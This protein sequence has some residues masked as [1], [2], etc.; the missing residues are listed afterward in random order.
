MNT[1]RKNKPERLRKEMAK[2]YHH[3]D[4]RSALLKAAK[5]ILDNQG[6]EAMSLRAV[7]NRAGVSPSAPYHHFK[8]KNDLLTAI[9]ASGFD[10][11]EKSLEERAAKGSTSQEKL[12][13]SGIAYV[14]FALA[15]TAL[16]Q[17]MFSG[18]R[19]SASKKNEVASQNN[20]YKTLEKRAQA[21]MHGGHSG[22][23]KAG[24]YALK[25]WASVHGLATLLID[26]AI[27][28]K[29]YGAKDAIE[30]VET[31]LGTAPKQSD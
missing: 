4:L 15:H 20:A 30:L 9:A 26:G 24:I 12:K 28:P 1:Q 23:T 19:V 21:V 2:R 25:A 27:T 3:G 16:F 7:A 11:F 6:V 8:D 5:D 31:V 22:D 10:A 14:E 13:L 17:L 29:T 18:I